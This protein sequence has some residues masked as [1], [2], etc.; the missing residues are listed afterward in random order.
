M[1]RENKTNAARLL[2]RAGTAYGL[3]SYPVDEEDL[4]AAHVAAVLGL[5]ADA[6]YKT[7]VLRGERTGVFVCVVPGDAEVDLKKA[8]RV[9]GNKK[10]DLVPMKELL[11]LTGYVRGGCSPIGM[12][13]RYPTYIDSGVMERETVHVSAGVRGMQLV[14][15]PADLI[16]CTGAVTAD[17]IIR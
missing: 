1:K 10:V 16:A 11:P 14:I 2:D 8:A 3:K 12:K 5:E 9:S 13:K 7:L 6:L 17:I 4:S 15:A